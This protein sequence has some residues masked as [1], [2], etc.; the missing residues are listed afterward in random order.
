[1]STFS[2]QPIGYAGDWHRYAIRRNTALFLLLCWIPACVGLFLLSRFW[3][4]QP[5][6][7]LVIMLLWLISMLTAV[8]WCGEFRCPRCR[9]RF[10]AL[11]HRRTANV[12]RGLFDKICANCKLARFESPPVR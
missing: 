8:W 5:K 3:L 11:G 10:G 4:H 12:T 1:M 2:E 9:R 6:L 7:S